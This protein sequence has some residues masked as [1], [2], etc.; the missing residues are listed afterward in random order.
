[1]SRI[2]QL[3]SFIEQTPQDPF[4]RYGL[5]IELKN[6]GRLE[7]AERT[8]AVLIEKFPD[9]TAAYLHA[10]GVLAM[11]GRKKDAA[12]LYRKGVE[13]CKRKHDAH[14]QGELEAA[15]AELGDG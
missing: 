7:E 2:E 13:A 3:Q 15:L 12:D 11:L 4:P 1:V 14:A 6:T 10:G 5:A 9:Y 8:F